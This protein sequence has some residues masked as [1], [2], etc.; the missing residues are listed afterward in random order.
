MVKRFKLGISASGD[1]AKEDDTSGLVMV[2][3]HW[4]ERVCY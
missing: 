4:I 1:F 3:G 2:L